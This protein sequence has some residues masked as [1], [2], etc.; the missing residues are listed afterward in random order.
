VP[1]VLAQPEP[2]IAFPHRDKV[3]ATAL[4]IAVAWKNDN[5]RAPLDDR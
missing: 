5:V 4:R 1:G 3:G 2:G